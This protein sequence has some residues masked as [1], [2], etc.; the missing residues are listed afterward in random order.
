M[1]NNRKTLTAAFEMNVI[2][3]KYKANKY[4][5]AE[6][7]G[8]QYITFVERKGMRVVHIKDKIVRI[9]G[10]GWGKITKKWN[11]RKDG[12]GLTRMQVE[13][14]PLQDSYGHVM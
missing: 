2:I 6:V 1:S 7:V 12:Q 8:T 11:I 5:P 10:H 3:G 13:I 4:T 14:E 9:E